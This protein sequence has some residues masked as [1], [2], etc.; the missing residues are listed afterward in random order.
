MKAK[1]VMM[2]SSLQELTNVS[3]S[4]I[5]LP[6]MISVTRLYIPLKIVFLFSIMLKKEKNF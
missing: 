1:K 5:V 6:V 3:A 4:G 2:A